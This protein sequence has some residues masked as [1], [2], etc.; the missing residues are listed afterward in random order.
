MITMTTA[1]ATDTTCLT[2]NLEFDT[3][4]PTDKD[5]TMFTPTAE[6]ILQVNPALLTLRR[7]QK[8]LEGVGEAIGLD[9]DEAIADWVT[10]S[11]RKER[12]AL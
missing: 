7:L 2:S 12:A 10:A 8:E 3:L 4:F 6:A 9:S 11:R 1:L 5:R